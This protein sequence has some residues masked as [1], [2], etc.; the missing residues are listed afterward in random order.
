MAIQNNFPI[1][2]PTLDLN[3]AGSQTVDPRIT[4]SR[5][6]T[7]NIASYFDN[8]GVMRFASP[9]TPR[10]DFDPVTGECNGLLIEEQRTNLLTYSEQFDNAAWSTNITTTKVTP[11]VVV[12]PNGLLVGARL[13]ENDTSTVVKY[14]GNTSGVS[15]ANNTIVTATIYAKA[16]E[17]SQIRFSLRKK[18]DTYASAVFSLSTS[19]VVIADSGYSGLITAVGN[20]WF[21]CSVTGS[22]GAG[23]S[24]HGLYAYVANNGT[25]I[26]I[27]DGTSGIYIWG[28]QLETGTFPTSY[29]PTT[30][31]QVTRAADVANMSGTNFSSWNNTTGTLLAKYRNS[32]WQHNNTPPTT[33]LDLTKYIQ[34]YSTPIVSDSIERMMF[35]SRQL[36]DAQISALKG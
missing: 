9:N 20:G 7:G 19:E 22:I 18:D 15:I 11:N 23:T 17:R 8:K 24:Q 6:G 32:G 29:I 30:S 36:T 26:Y 25:S 3:F 31:S 27:G 21:R 28:A 10:I 5:P 16:A 12:A 2:R 35:Y 1:I 13:S 14:V 33:Q 4:F 34:N